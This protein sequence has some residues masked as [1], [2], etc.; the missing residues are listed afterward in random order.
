MWLL[1]RMKTHNQRG[2]ATLPRIKFVTLCCRATGCGTHAKK[3][4]FVTAYDLRQ[5]EAD[6]A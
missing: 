5:Q 4:C 2:L 3:Y 1:S 6:L